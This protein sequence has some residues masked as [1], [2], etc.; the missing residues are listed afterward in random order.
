MSM[1][2]IYKWLWG[3]GV[4][5]SAKATQ[6]DDLFAITV[7]EGDMITDGETQTAVVDVSADEIETDDGLTHDK[8]MVYLTLVSTSSDVELVK[9]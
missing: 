9:E 1:W 3:D 2:E 5:M 8:E 7:E 4:D 6:T